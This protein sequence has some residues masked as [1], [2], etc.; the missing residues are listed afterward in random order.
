MLL[1]LT[2]EQLPQQ[3]L[4]KIQYFME[5]SEHI[6]NETRQPPLGDD[7]RVRAADTIDV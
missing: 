3:M 5:V 7:T 6:G 2:C 1:A 4:V